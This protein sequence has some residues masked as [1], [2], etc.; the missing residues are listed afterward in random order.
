MVRRRKQQRMLLP[1]LLASLLWV[2]F[3]RGD[4]GIPAL[5]QFAEQYQSKKP[6]MQSQ[7]PESQTVPEMPKLEPPRIVSGDTPV[8]PDR[9]ALRRQIK[10]QESVIAQQKSEMSSLENQLKSLRQSLSSAQDALA[11]A[12]QEKQTLQDAAHRAPEKVVVDLTP[13]SDFL[14]RLRHAV[15]GT[16]HETELKKLLAAAHDDVKSRDTLLAASRQETDM[17]KKQIDE[18]R[19]TG[20]SNSE[21]L[22][23]VQKSGNEA[24]VLISELRQ[25]LA[26]EELVH[27]AMKKAQIQDAVVSQSQQEELTSLKG[28]LQQLEQGASQKEAEMASLREENQSLTIQ[29]D[30]QKSLADES[31]AMKAS[32]EQEIVAYKARIE[33]IPETG[34]KQLIADA[35]KKGEGRRNYA[36]GSLLGRDIIDILDERDGWGLKSD[37]EIVLAGIIDSFSGKYRLSH[38]ELN[39]ALTESELQVS[40]AA[41]DMARKQKNKGEAFIEEFKK[42]KGVKQSASGFWYHIDYPGDEPVADN[43]IIDVVVKESLTD[44]T[45]IQDMDVNGKVLSQPLEAYPALFQEAIRYLKNHGS[46]TLVVP[47]SLAYGEA[48]YPPKI[49]PDSTMVYVLRIDHA[50]AGGEAKKSNVR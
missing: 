2:Q 24:Q 13:F 5:L 35:L 38:E 7:V 42:K 30:T 37:R 39:T 34:Q 48:G 26:D 1:T 22:A 46:V 6:A 14:G 17:L 47:P 33:D 20:R 28:Q 23:Q 32:L 4:D 41:A 11:M 16:P 8:Q 50:S 10:Q 19:T 9:S 31:E 29:L 21:E 15:T 12:R 3:A 25:R 40:K 18:L 49:P 27:A 36:E 43:A 45:V 44:G